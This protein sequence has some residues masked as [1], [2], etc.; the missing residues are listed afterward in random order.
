MSKKFVPAEWISIRYLS[1]AGEGVGRSVILR[2]SGPLSWSVLS[3]GQFGQLGSG[4]GKLYLDITADLNCAHCI[5]VSSVTAF[6]LILLFSGES[7]AR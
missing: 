4:L 7:I 1:G 3:F 5:L 2:S 6:R